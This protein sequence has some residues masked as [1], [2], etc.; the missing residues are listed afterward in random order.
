MSALRRC[1]WFGNDV[2]NQ[3]NNALCLTYIRVCLSALQGMGFEREA[4]VA[5]LRAT[6]NNVEAA[7][8]NLLR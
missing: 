3:R 5:A 7:A 4:V 8:N 6:G 2:K 1:D